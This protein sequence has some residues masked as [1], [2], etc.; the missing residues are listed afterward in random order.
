MR[1]VKRPV[2]RPD[3]SK[4]PA[5][6]PRDESLRE[7]ILKAAFAAFT[8]LGYADASTLE[9]ATRAKVSKR[10]LY[11]CFATKEA[12][13]AAC[14]ES[15]A[16]SMRRP[17]DLPRID[18]RQ[19]LVGTL[20]ALGETLLREASH[21]T[22]VGVYR[23][24]IAESQRSPEIA[25]ILNDAGREANHAALAAMLA[26][27]RQRGLIAEGDTRSM[28]A[29]F[30]ALLWGDLLLRLVLGVAKRPTAAQATLRAREA[31]SAFLAL[32]E[33]EPRR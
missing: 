14:I 26:Q 9:I 8:E 22:V 13:L 3:A 4:I 11:A 24:A 29:Q 19:D 2:K 5:S 6:A 33:P 10:E 23:L 12:M 20:H 1:A 21:P 28:A 27:A 18:S 30:L 31:A 25:R 16:A 15:R 32:H 7:R 17:L